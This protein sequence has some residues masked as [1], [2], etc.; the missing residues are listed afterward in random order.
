[1]KRI[2]IFFILCAVAIAASVYLSFPH[3]EF[4]IGS[5]SRPLPIEEAYVKPVVKD[6]I[7]FVGDVMLARNVENMMDTF[8]YQ[9]PFSQL[10]P[11][12]DDAYLVGNFEGSIPLVHVPTP[13][14][15]FSFSIDP[16]YVK[17]LSEYGFTH[18]GFANNHAYDFGSDDFIQSTKVA[19]LHD[20]IWFG[21]PGNL[22]TSSIAVIDVGTSTVGIVGIY[23]V[24][25]PPTTAE[26]V[27]IF[28]HA[29]EMSDYQIAYVHFGDEYVLK[30]SAAQERLAHLFIDAGADAVIGHHP[31]VVQDIQ[32]YKNAPI[33]YSLGN[34]IF[35]QYFSEDVQVGL[36]LEVSLAEKNLRFELLPYTSI[37]SRSAPRAMG[38]YEERNFLEAIAKKS[39]TELGGMIREGFVEVR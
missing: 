26:I 9:Y 38:L 17:G 5:F 3:T 15:Q 32:M 7:R 16:Q 31:H 18:I 24:A 33:F 34:F 30:H 27:Q 11:N 19:E 37:G 23:A 22:A 10:S 25:T 8:G 12:P 2:L 20:L 1:M 39:D 36:G 35:D 28:K 29:S 4:S 6:K 13:S 21:S 14:M